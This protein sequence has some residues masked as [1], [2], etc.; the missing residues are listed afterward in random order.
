MI[1]NIAIVTGGNGGLGSTF[2]KLLNEYSDI[3]QIWVI[4]RNEASLNKLKEE[5]GN[6]IIPVSLDLTNKDSFSEIKR[7]LQKEKVNVKYLINNAGY[8]K[9]GNYE[10]IS[11]EQSINMINLNSIAVVQMVLLTLPF[12]EEESKIINIASQ[13]SFQPLPYFNL[14]AATKAFVRSYSRALNVELKTKKISVTAVCPGW[15][16][17]PLLD[18]IK[19]NDTHQYKFK[20]AVSADKVAKKALKD[21]N[22][23]K[24]ISVFSFYVKLNHVA[25]KLLPQKLIMKIWMR[26]QKLNRR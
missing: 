24:D 16:E 14:Y 25:T 9:F 21:A 12:M 7:I 3:Q 11:E 17:T 8:G 6:K 5:L 4:A 13:A 22:K 18:K 10:E 2:V 26:Q 23:N 15:I 1:K 19:N 20:P